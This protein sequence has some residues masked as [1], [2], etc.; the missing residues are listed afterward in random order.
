M[1]DYVYYGRKAVRWAV[2]LVLAFLA[3]RVVPVYASAL[4]FRFALSEACMTGAS[5]RLPVD[6]IRD[7]I[8]FKARRLELPVGP[9]HIEIHKD[10]I[11]VKARVVYQVPVNLAMRQVTL[12]FHATAEEMPMVVSV[13]GGDSLKKVLE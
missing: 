5:G 7:D 9:E 12:K 3:W 10:G 6:D 8:L 4:R 13:D 11:Y 1:V 2:I